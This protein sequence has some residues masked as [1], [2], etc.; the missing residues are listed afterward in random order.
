MATTV[1]GEIERVTYENEETGFRVI[2]VGS[3][4][5][6][7]AREPLSVVG[8]FQPVGAGTRVRVTGSYVNDPRHGE[9]F[10]ADTLVPLEPDTLVGLERYLSSGLIRG[11]GPGF[12]KRIVAKFGVETLTVL[13]QEPTRIRE[14]PGL[15]A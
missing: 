3:I 6:R 1:I 8:V 13:D 2:K 9:Q 5:G 14:V 10:R 7:R 11:I 12:A 15:G 4:Q